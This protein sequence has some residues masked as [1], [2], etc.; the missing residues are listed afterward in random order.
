MKEE[1]NSSK[2][3]IVDDEE[4]NLRLIQAMLAPQD[5]EV[6]FARN[7]K[8][9]LELAESISPDLILLDV[10]MPE[11]DGFAVTQRLKGNERT[12]T[13][14][15][16]IIT[17][18]QNIDDKVKALDYGADDFLSKPVEK[19]E[20]RARVKSLL[21]VKAYNDHMISFQECLKKEVE[22]KTTQLKITLDSLKQTSLDTI[23]RLSRAAEYKDEDTG[24]HI[25][26]VSEFA[27]ALARRLGISGEREELILYAAPLHDI[28]KIGIPENILMKPGKLDSDEWEIMK[29]HTVIGSQILGGSETSYLR[30]A[31]I[32]ALTHHERWDGDGYPRGLKA[33]DIPLEGRITAVVDVYDA[34]TSKRP[35]RGPLATE[36]ALE[37][38]QDSRG[39]HLDPE[40]V[41][42]FLDIKEEIWQIAKKFHT[43]G[44]T[45]MIQWNS[46]LDRPS[47]AD[48]VSRQHN[49]V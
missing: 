39:T 15:I 21:K 9:S 29:L 24:N 40:C 19:I 8:E 5:Y 12:K 2:I 33:E 3:L 10:M 34:L 23:I 13:I 25:S 11:L 44:S 42:A 46:L 17:A 20:L 6:H 1:K 4:R 48:A 28:G 27:A 38:I 43:A 31:E 47:E 22:D 30:M 16:V 14:P 7:G 36:K 35:Y 18:L 26:R 45:K 41:D 37:I 49:K 32:I